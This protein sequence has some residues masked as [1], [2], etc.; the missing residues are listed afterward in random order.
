MRYCSDCAAPIVLELPQGDTRQRAVCTACHRIFYSNPKTVCGCILS[1]GSKILLCKRAIDPSY[2]KWT[3]PAGFMENSETTS[4]CAAR[5]ALEETH[6][7]VGTLRLFG[8]YSLPTINQLYIFYT[9]QLLSDSIA[10]S[11]ESLA[12]GLYEE[13]AI[14]WDDLAFAVVERTL[15]HYY[16]DRALNLTQVHEAEL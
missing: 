5:E 2:G 8:L 6:A 1:W 10:T 15:R 16:Q 12:V 4:A 11:S 7:Q 14:P 13:D 3:L 9:G